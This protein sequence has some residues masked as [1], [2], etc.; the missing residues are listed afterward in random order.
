MEVNHYPAFRVRKLKQNS[1]DYQLLQL[2]SLPLS[3]L[4]RPASPTRGS[5][6]VWKL[7][8]GVENSV[9]KC[10]VRVEYSVLK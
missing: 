4:R 1:S 10:A 2:L 3:R 5:K 7:G 6:I 9:S 8:W